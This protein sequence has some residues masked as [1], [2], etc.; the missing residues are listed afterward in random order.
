L[1]LGIAAVVTLPINC[2]SPN[3]FFI[4]L[5]YYLDNMIAPLLES[6]IKLFLGEKGYLIIDNSKKAIKNI[7]RNI[8][9]EI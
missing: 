1:N 8:Y 2:L 5:S 4:S 6:F 7:S 3:I 9:L